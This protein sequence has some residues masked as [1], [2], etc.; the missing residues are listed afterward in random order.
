MLMVARSN[1]KNLQEPR[2]EEEGKK[3]NTTSR[4]NHFLNQNS[5][6]SI[7]NVDKENPVSTPQEE[8]LTIM[9]NNKVLISSTYSPV[10]PNCSNLDFTFGPTSS[11]S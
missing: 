9:P 6:Q 5:C 1:C 3:E 8:S 7:M 10:Q 11:C 2:E 4:I